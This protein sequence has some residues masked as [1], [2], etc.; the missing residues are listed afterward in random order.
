ME[1]FSA[2]NWALSFEDIGFLGM[3]PPKICVEAALQLCSVRVC[4]RFIED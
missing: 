2:R 4:G 1:Q 3:L